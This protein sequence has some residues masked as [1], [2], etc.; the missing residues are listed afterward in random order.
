MSDPNA[1][2]KD[3]ISYSSSLDEVPSDAVIE[4]TVENLEE[5]GFSVV[6]T[7]SAGEAL[8]TIRSRIPAD[9]SVMT[10]HSNT[11]DEIGF[12]E[13]LMDGDHNWENL[14]GE[15]QRIEDREERQRSRRTA[16]TADYF[17]GSV[18]AVARTGELVAADHGSARIGAYP[19]AAENLVLV[20]GSNKIVP[21]LK[22][23]NARLEKVAYPLEEARAEKAYGTE[24]SIGK[25]LIYRQEIIRGR[26]T[27]VLI[28][29]RFGF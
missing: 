4:T 1:N 29:G 20:S 5:R 22:T 19:Y 23:A 15:I 7:D 14:R 2:L 17:L 26:T 27:V 6:V 8:E 13:Y 16:L 11:L 21:D 25:Q 9:M 24:S 3:T 18:N 28:R 10:G 12:I